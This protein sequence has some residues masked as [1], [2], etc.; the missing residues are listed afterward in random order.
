MLGGDHHVGNAVQRVR[1]GGENSQDVILWFAWESA[2]FPLSL[3]GIVLIRVPD[4][5]VNFGAYALAD[6]VSL[7]G[8]NALRPIQVV[9]PL[10]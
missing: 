7:Q 2:N 3:P 8:F 4:I 9:E 1:T 6:P 5:E 10:F